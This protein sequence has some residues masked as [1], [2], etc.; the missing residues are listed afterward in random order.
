MSESFTFRP[1]LH[2]RGPQRATATF[3]RTFRLRSKS[4]GFAALLGL[5]DRDIDVG[6][7]FSDLLIQRSD[8]AG[9]TIMLKQLGGRVTMAVI[10]GEKEGEMR[11]VLPDGRT[12][13]TRILPQPDGTIITDHV[14]ELPEPIP[15]PPAEMAPPEPPRRKGAVQ[16][17][18]D[19][20]P[21]PLF[22][23]DMNETIRAC[24]KEFESWVGRLRK[25]VVGASPYEILPR[26]M[27]EEMLQSIGDLPDDGQRLAFDRQ[28]MDSKGRIRSVRITLA[29]LDPVP[30]TT[31]GTLVTILDLTDVKTAE[32]NSRRNAEQLR[33]MLEASPAAVAIMRQ[34]DGTILF[35]NDRL[36]SMIGRRRGRMLVGDDGNGLLLQ[37]ALDFIVQDIRTNGRLSD[38]DGAITMENG[39]PRQLL[40]TI[41]LVE[42]ED[43]HAIIWWSYDVTKLH[44]QQTRLSQAAY[45]DKLTGIPNR[46]AFDQQLRGAINS[47][48]R[49]GKQQALMFFDLDGFKSVNDT[50]GHEAGDCVLQEAAERMRETLRPGDFVARLGGDEFAALLPD[51]SGD[52]EITAVAERVN[53][54]IREPF[55]WEGNELAIGVSIGIVVI[56]GDESDPA[57]LKKQ[58]D[59]AMYEAKRAGKNT[60][61]IYRPITLEIGTSNS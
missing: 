35:A 38:Y 30:G 40:M 4:A 23:L 45:S 36:G 34:R 49:L 6:T 48:R 1:R 16:Q 41:D 37:G 56:T 53:L 7:A 18:I 3:D 51:A 31:E 46:A 54:A 58:A 21:T 28:M 52:E 20:I 29:R 39:S 33:T 44:S 59:L 8:P 50:H 2:R 42:Y 10:R 11:T 55:K 19:T 26:S 60:F 24:N 61:R 5:D 57:M 12:I 22:F 9:A 27:V 17:L 13:V 14:E 32:A 25:A 43:E 15:R 47:A